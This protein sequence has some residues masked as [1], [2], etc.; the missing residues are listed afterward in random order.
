MTF[1]A[2]DRAGVA[3]RMAF[4]FMK[5]K[6]HRFVVIVKLQGARKRAEA[7]L[8]AAMA[9]RQPDSCEFHLRSRPPINL[10]RE[11]A[12]KTI[13]PVGRHISTYTSGPYLK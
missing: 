4:E 11:S 12:H 6:E 3:P 1:P 8:L 13:T 10:R 5:Q 9:L 7:A 2:Q